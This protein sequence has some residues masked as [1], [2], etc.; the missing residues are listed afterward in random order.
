V[1][2]SFESF[3]GNGTFQTTYADGKPVEAAVVLDGIDYD[4]AP[5]LSA[6]LAE[7]ESFRQCLVQRFGHFVMGAEFGAPVTVR[8]SKEA[9]DAFQESDGSFEELLVAVVRD[10]SFIERRK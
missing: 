10:R 5:A 2:L 8:A 3:A 9:Y 4:N 6:A 1:G 7:D